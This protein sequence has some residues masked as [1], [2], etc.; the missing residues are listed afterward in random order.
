[1]KKSK[2]LKIRKNEKNNKLCFMKKN[3]KKMKK[4]NLGFLIQ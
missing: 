4:N 3:K 2:Y 1:M